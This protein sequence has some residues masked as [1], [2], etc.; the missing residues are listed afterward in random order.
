MVTPW[1]IIITTIIITHIILHIIIRIAVILFGFM[2][3]CLQARC[4]W[5]DFDM[6]AHVWTLCYFSNGLMNHAFYM[7]TDV[8][9]AQAP[10]LGRNRP[11]SL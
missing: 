9:G 5:Y 11:P 10:D 7:Y 1:D 3:K 8:R 4:V 6:S 2:L